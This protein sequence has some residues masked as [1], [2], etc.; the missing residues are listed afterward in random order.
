[1]DLGRT[2]LG[3]AR[4]QRLR[5]LSVIIVLSLGIIA[6]SQGSG[7]VR[8]IV[9]EVEGDLSEVTAFTVLVEGELIRYMPLENGDYAFPLP[10]LREHQRSGEPVLVGWETVDGERVAVSLDDG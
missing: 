1:M 7:T 9:V 4:A 10:H 2:E 3:G 6:C 8:G 5:Q